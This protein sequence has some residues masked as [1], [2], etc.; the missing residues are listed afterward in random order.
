MPVKESGTS[1]NALTPIAKFAKTDCSLMI[2]AVGVWIE[3]TN[4]LISS[5][6]LKLLTDHRM[7]YRSNAMI[8]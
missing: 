1:E 2:N 6:L 7:W 3:S 4:C 8:S 5:Y